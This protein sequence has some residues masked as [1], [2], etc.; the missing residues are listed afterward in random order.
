M[1]SI[2]NLSRWYVFERAV[3]EDIKYNRGKNA[4]VVVKRITISDIHTLVKQLFSLI[5]WMMLNT[6]EHVIQQRIA[7]SL[8]RTR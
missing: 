7:F 1:R 2:F 8:W 3:E 4:D 5:Q 6:K